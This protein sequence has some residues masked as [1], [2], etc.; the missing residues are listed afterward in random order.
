MRRPWGILSVVT[1]AATHMRDNTFRT[2]LL[3]VAVIVLIASSA[4]AETSRVL[5]LSLRSEEAVA[6][7]AN[8]WVLGS[9]EGVP[10]TWCEALNASPAVVSAGPLTSIGIVRVGLDPGL[11]VTEVS[12]SPG[13][14]AAF[15]GRAPSY[16]GGDSPIVGGTLAASLGLRRGD[17]VPLNDVPTPIAGVAAEGRRAGQADRWII[18]P[19]MSEETATECWVE[20][21]ESD[22]STTEVLE[23]GLAVYVSGTTL[24]S[25]SDSALTDLRAARSE[26]PRRSE[27]RGWLYSVAGIVL[28]WW[29]ISWA[30]RGDH[31]IYRGMGAPRHF[32]VAVQT[33]EIMVLVLFAGETVFLALVVYIGSVSP[34]GPPQHVMNLA[35]VSVLRSSAAVV[36]CAPALSILHGRRDISKL[37]KDR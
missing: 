22:M 23:S 8:V 34:A 17:V 19:S 11:Y 36:L 25:F 28:L 4:Y 18:W 33:A 9:D 14:V 37:L 20:L 12:A 13:A 21:V 29:A 15:S 7:G 32:G 35:A 5:Q 3:L 16:F 2:L 27:S 1:D 30:R 10:A 6:L 31:G 26:F 24:A